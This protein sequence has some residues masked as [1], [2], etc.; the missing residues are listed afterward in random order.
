MSNSRNIIN[1]QKEN[2]KF[3][4]NVLTLAH[5][6]DEI[7]IISPL[8]KFYIELGL[9][10]DKVY[11]CIQYLENTPFKSFV[12]QLVDIRVSSVETNNPALGDRAKFCLN[13]AVGKFGLNKS[14]F[15][16]CSFVREENLAIHTRQAHCEKQK[17]LETEFKTGLHEVCKKYRTI[18]DDVPVHVSLFVYQRSKLLFFRFIVTLHEYLVPGGFKICYCDTD[19]ILLALC[20]E[21]L[22]ESVKPEKR[23]EWE[24]VIKPKWFATNTPRSSKTPGA[25]LIN[26]FQYLFFEQLNL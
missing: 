13:S 20:Y 18:H 15:R 8:L 3:P 6:A 23:Q 25:G 10:V 17:S 2:R 1:F 9:T 5:N 7:L 14:R 11:Y 21:S 26:L 22:D 16:H 4:Q 19:S 24:D 12:D